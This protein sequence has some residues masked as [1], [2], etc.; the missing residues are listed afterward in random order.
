MF[1]IA[2]RVSNPSFDPKFVLEK[3]IEVVQNFGHLL[4]YSIVT[5]TVFLQYYSSR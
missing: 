4:C 1:F 3:M 5:T 2:F